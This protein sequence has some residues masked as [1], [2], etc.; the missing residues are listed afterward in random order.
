MFRNQRWPWISLALV[1]AG[2]FLAATAVTALAQ[3]GEN[4]PSSCL[5]CHQQTDPILDKGEWHQI[6]SRK[7]ICVNCH[8]GNALAADKA[9]AHLGLVA[10]P[11]GDTYLS[12]HACHPDD[13]PVRAARFGAALGIVPQSEPTPTPRPTSTGGAQALIVLPTL[14]PLTNPIQ[15]SMPLAWAL[16]VVTL[17]LMAW[18]ALGWRRA[19]R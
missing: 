4:P 19:A 17:A 11:L 6:H 10:Q 1:A 5:S 13:Y 14:A 16:A 8:G 7:D 9:Q 12:C 3:C 2:L 18:I 15:L